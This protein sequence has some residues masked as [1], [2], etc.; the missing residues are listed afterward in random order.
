MRL[1]NI[2]EVDDVVIVE[3]IFIVVNDRKKYVLSKEV[4]ILNINMIF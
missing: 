3:V 1:G 4:C 2:W